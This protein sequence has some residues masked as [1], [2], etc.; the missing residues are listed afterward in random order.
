MSAIVVD[1]AP[2]ASPLASGKKMG[3]QGADIFELIF[4]DCR[5]PR[6]IWW[7]RRAKGSGSP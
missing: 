5:V 6:A 3:I 4:E 2:P 7:A 1:R